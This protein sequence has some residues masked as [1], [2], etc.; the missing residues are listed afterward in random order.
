MH[1]SSSHQLVDHFF[2]H[3]SGRLVAVLTAEFGVRRLE[4]AEDAVQ[5]ALSRALQTWG[6]GGVPGNPSGWLFRVARNYLIDCLRRHALEL[7]YQNQHSAALSESIGSDDVAASVDVLADDEISDHSLRLLFLCC[8]PAL[9]FES[10][11]ALALKLVGGFSVREIATA[12]LITKANAEKRIYRA[13]ETLREEAVELADLDYG[14]MQARLEAV[15]STLYLMFNEGYA[16]LSNSAVLRRDVCEEAVRLCRM[17]VEHGNAAAQNTV[18][19]PATFAL[20]ALMLMHLA[21][22]DARLSQD[23]AIIVMEDQDRGL[24]NYALIREA[25][26]WM[27]AS[28][29]DQQISRYHI[30]AAIAWEHC[31]ATSFASIEWQRIVE[32]YTL[33]NQKYPSPMI[34]LNLAIASMYAI[35]NETGLQQLVAID[36]KDRQRLRPWWDAALA[37]V[38]QRLGNFNEA[39]AHFQDALALTDNPT[40]KQ[41]FVARLEQIAYGIKLS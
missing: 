22:F 13:M 24:W 33:L 20:L 8:H 6:L 34:R 32:L 25:M 12:L 27:A 19:R 30:E 39:A 37:T 14:S 35:G 40:L 38:H 23:G 18:A 31:R 15:E 4:L 26:D 7:R 5:H 1:V 29:K 3:E 41:F 21:R 10:R 36:G 17:L 9:P 28:T 11:V 16:S 2:R